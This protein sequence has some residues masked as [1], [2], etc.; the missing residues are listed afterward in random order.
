MGGNSRWCRRLGIKH[1]IELYV[2]DSSL[3]AICLVARGYTSWNARAL[4][5]GNLV[6]LAGLDFESQR[7][8]DLKQAA[9]TIYRRHKCSSRRYFRYCDRSPGARPFDSRMQ[10]MRPIVAVLL[11]LL[12]MRRGFAHDESVAV[13]SSGGW[14][15][16]PW[17]VVPVYI[18]AISF[19]LGTWRLWRR[20]GFGRGILQWQTVCFWTGWSVLV[21][22]LMSPLHSIAERM[23]TAHMIEHELIMA[24]AAPLIVLSRPLIA[25]LWSVPILAR[26]LLGTM[27]ALPPIVSVWPLL[28]DASFA[29][30]CLC[31]AAPNRRIIRDRP[32]RRNS[33]CLAHAGSFRGG[34]HL[35]NFAQT[36]TY[37]LSRDGSALLVGST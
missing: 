17:L 16:D 15:F 11:Y 37:E 22:A 33:V 34:T 31:M 32:T 21:L 3:R 5:W 1:P 36:P 14:N 8:F 27:A 13:A 35:S 20:A 25:F 4:R 28:T 2:G 9:K 29:T 12:M 18:V 6:I 26:R 23:L 24:V 30:A 19:L 10:A 7:N